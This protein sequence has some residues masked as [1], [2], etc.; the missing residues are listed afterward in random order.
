MKMRLGA[1]T[2]MLGILAAAPLAGA[3]T[4]TIVGGTTNVKLTSLDL[5][6]SL[7]IDLELLGSA[8]ISGST[9]TFPI[10]GGSVDSAT[11]FSLVEHNGSGISLGKDEDLVELANFFIDPENS[12]L[13]GLVTVNGGLL[14]E[15]I[16]LFNITSGLRLNL[17]SDAA[18][19]LSSVFGVTIPAGTE[20]GAASVRPKTIPVPAA[21]WLMLGGLAGLGGLRKSI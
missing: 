1:V 7:G 6:A 13:S 21:L 10:T 5:F 12:I 9:V 14:G 18:T 4:L 16:P 19:A 20:I 15:D 3:T 17:T 8:T 11:G 2:L